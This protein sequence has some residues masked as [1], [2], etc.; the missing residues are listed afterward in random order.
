MNTP[1]TPALDTAAG[2][3]NVGGDAS[4]YARVLRR[5]GESFAG[6]PDAI[7][8]ALAQDQTEQA[9]RLAH[10]LKGAAGTIGAE[11]LQGAA[12]R[13]EQSLRAGTDDC[14]GPLGDVA[15]ELL[16]VLREIDAMA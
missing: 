5:F 7:L 8:A 9:E 16:R 1:A 14:G 4:M 15:A 11:M 6:T 3:A 13:L 12:W 10:T 2:V